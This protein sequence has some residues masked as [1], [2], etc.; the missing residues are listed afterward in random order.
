MTYCKYWYTHMLSTSC[1]NI[2]IYILFWCEFSQHTCINIYKKVQILLRTIS[3][4]LNATYVFCLVNYFECQ[5]WPRPSSRRSPTLC[6]NAHAQAPAEAPLCATMP[7]P[8]PLPVPHFVRQHPRPASYRP[9]MSCCYFRTWRDRWCFI[10]HFFEVGDKSQQALQRQ[11]HVATTKN[12][13]CLPVSKYTLFSWHQFRP[14]HTGAR[15][16]P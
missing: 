16:Q 8:L 12:Q 1:T 10:D 3:I 9:A 4:I 7:T 5:V 13:L 6:D 14:K 2:F 15:L 11:T